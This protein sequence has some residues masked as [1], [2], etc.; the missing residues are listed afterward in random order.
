MSVTK[1]RWLND[2]IVWPDGAKVAVMLAFE[3]DG[4]T[5]WFNVDK[6]VWNWPKTY[7]LGAYGPWR[8]LPRV[9]DLLDEHNVRATFFTPGWV[10]E[11]WPERFRDI[12]QSGHEVAHHGYLHEQFEKLSRTEQRD[13]IRKSQEIFDRH[14]GIRAKGFRLPSGDFGP[15][16]IDLLVEEGFEYSSSMR[17]DDRPY[18]VKSSSGSDIIEIPARW[19]LDDYVQFIYNLALPVPKGGDRIASHAATLDLWWTEFNGYHELGLCYVLTLETQLIGK[20]GRIMML[21]ELIGRIKQSPSVWFAT[22]SQIAKWWRE[23][24]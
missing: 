11:Q 8:G 12:S 9:L 21:D 16:T 20:P 17:G 4:P 14:C 1:N 7:S 24:Y 22:G 23:K 6:R 2:N 5:N 18:R 15:D 10:A 3:V 13:I 19:E